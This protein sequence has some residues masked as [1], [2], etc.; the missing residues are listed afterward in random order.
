MRN[1]AVKYAQML[2]RLSGGAIVESLGS[3]SWFPIDGRLGSVKAA[4]QAEEHFARVSRLHP[5]MVGFEIRIGYRDG[6]PRGTGIFD[7]YTVTSGP[8]VLK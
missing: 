7:N 8:W 3:D 6:I 4:K 2:D 1:R 5:M